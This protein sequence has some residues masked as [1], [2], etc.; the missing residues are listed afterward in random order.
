M[1][2]WI[3]QID[4]WI[5]CNLFILTRNTQH[6]KFLQDIHHHF[7]QLSLLA[8]CIYPLY[9]LVSKF[10]FSMTHP[11]LL[12]VLK[13]FSKLIFHWLPRINLRFKKNL[14]VY[15]ILDQAKV[16]FHIPLYEYRV[17]VRSLLTEYN[18]LFTA[19]F[20]I[21]IMINHIWYNSI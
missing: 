12:D 19:E 13:I 5:F 16:L 9:F 18:G 3:N 7:F 17:L 14:H 2:Y 4:F 8:V 6:R 20:S 1:F 15:Q 10:K 11:Y 21:F